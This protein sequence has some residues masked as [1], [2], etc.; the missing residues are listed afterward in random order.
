MNTIEEKINQDL[1]HQLCDALKNLYHLINTPIVR[2]KLPLSEGYWVEAL[3]EA[4][5]VIKA[6]DGKMILKNR[7][8]NRTSE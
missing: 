8:G 6:H 2:R 4:E 5:R 1:E 3:E 7:Y